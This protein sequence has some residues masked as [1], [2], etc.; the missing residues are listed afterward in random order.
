MGISPEITGCQVGWSACAV[1]NIILGFWL[2]A[3]PESPKF[4]YEIGE[5]DK[6]LNILQHMYA[7]NTNRSPD[8]FPIKTLKE[9]EKSESEQRLYGDRTVRQLRIRRPRE[10]ALLLKEIWTQ[11]KNLCKKPHLRNTALTCFIQFGLTMSYL[12]D[13]AYPMHPVVFHS[14][15]YLC[16]YLDSAYLD[17]VSEFISFPT[18]LKPTKLAVLNG[19]RLHS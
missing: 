7:V 3:F 2:F 1:E 11:T 10:L 18:G 19:D 16:T 12:M 9:P 6:A 15:V 8:D 5:T 14:L 17:S 13:S 4:H